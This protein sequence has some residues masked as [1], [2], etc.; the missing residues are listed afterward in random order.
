MEKSIRPISVCI[1][2][3]KQHILV[4]QG[5]D[6]SKN[7]TFYRPLGGGI[8]F[9][10]SSQEALHREIK[11]ELQADIHSATLLGILENRFTYENEMGHEIVFVYDA[12]FENTRLYSRTEISVIE[13]GQT[14]TAT[15]LPIAPLP[16]DTRLY[17][18]GI[19]SLLKQPSE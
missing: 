9:G 14:L 12:R 15:W 17:P 7:Q 19:V 6:A 13:A 10:E 16:P 3:H 11:E 5:F 4:Y 1:F 18:P 8:E 2:R